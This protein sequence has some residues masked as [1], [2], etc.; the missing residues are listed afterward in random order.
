MNNH[1]EASA[2]DLDN[3]LLDDSDDFDM[4]INPF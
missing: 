1:I 3:M 4:M 2:N